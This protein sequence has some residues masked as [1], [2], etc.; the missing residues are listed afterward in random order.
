MP[1]GFAPV[2]VLAS[3]GGGKN[4]RAV[5]DRAGAQQYMPVRFAGL[6]RE[7]GWNA[8]KRRARVRQ[9]AIERGKAQIV[10]NSQS[11]PAPW[12]IGSHR[13]VARTVIARFTIAFAIGEIDVEHVD[14]VVARD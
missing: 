1:E 13:E 7:G 3:L 2:L 14:F 6:A 10:A 8:E 12:Q 11:K 9:R 4:E 5:L